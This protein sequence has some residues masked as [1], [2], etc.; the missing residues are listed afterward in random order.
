MGRLA[1]TLNAFPQFVTEIDG[2][3]I[4]FI[5]VES[6]HEGALPLI[7]HGV[8]GSV[9]EMLEN[10]G[11][12]ADPTANGGRA[13]DALD[14]VMP[15]LPSYGFPE[16]PASVGWDPGRTA[17]AWAVLADGDA[18]L[19][20]RMYW[21]GQRTTAAAA[22]SGQ[23]PPEVSLPIA[24]MVFPGEIFRGPRSRATR[25]YQTSST[26]TRSTGRPLRGLGGAGP[27]RGEMRA[28]FKSLRLTRRVLTPKPDPRSRHSYARNVIT[29][30]RRQT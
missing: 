18:D 4:H 3:D 7:T 12:L 5:H 25:V 10:I 11:L 23:T 28:A 19:A 16:Q 1:E 30:H 2:L 26:S 21:E 17:Q 22:A 8:P 13:E 6:A 15:S 27:V 14:L 20:A 24:I 9:V 29:R